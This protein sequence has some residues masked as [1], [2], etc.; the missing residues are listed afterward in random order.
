MNRTEQSLKNKLERIKNK[1][2]DVKKTKIVQDKKIDCLRDDIKESEK[3]YD[4]LESEIRREIV[5]Q[6]ESESK[7]NELERRVK[8]FEYENWGIQ[9]EFQKL[10]KSL[11]EEENCHQ[12]KE[13]Q[14]IAELEL[15]IL[16]SRNYIREMNEK[17]ING[18]ITKKTKE[19]DK[20]A[21]ELRNAENI[22]LSELNQKDRK[23]KPSIL[24]ETKSEKKKKAEMDRKNN[25]R[26]KIERLEKSNGEQKMENDRL[27]ER[28]ELLNRRLEKIGNQRFG[29][30][31]K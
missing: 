22:R 3:S 26:E 4:K 28:T 7:K 5:R 6:L 20:C 11:N 2:E 15:L 27:S 17:M 8:I 31:G 21:F 19:A 12:T 13:Q 18:S 24:I 25:L 29:K 9:D 16:K 14:K 1:L 10:L 23:M 30:N